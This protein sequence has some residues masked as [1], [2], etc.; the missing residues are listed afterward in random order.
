MNLFRIS[1]TDCKQTYSGNKEIAKLAELDI[2]LT[3]YVA[4]HTWATVLKRE[5]VSTSIISEGM[6]HSS[7]TTTQ[8]YLD[9][10]GD[11]VLDEANKSIL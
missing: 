3:S 7:E 10:F 8:I 1:N 6:K 5:N 9:S 11:D 4:R 2:S